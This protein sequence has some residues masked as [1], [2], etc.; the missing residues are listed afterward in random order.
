LDNRGSIPGRGWEVFSSTRRPGRS[1]GPPN[2]LSSGYRG[3][4]SWV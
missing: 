2:L 1:W 3:L 4:F